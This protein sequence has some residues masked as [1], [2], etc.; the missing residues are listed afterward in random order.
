M[1]TQHSNSNDTQTSHFDTTED[2]NLPSKKE[3][4]FSLES[5][6]HLIDTPQNENTMIQNSTDLI[7]PSTL[8]TTIEILELEDGKRTDKKT[9][10]KQMLSFFEKSPT[11]DSSIVNRIS[12][13]CVSNQRI[14]DLLHIL[15]CNAD[16]E[17][18]A[19]SLLSTI[20]P[21]TFSDYEDCIFVSAEFFAKNIKKYEILLSIISATA[22][23][24]LRG[25]YPLLSVTLRKLVKNNCLQQATQFFNKLVENKIEIS[26]CSINLLVEN[27]CKANK[28]E[29]AQNIM[30]SLTDYKPSHTFLSDINLDDEDTEFN[31]TKLNIACGISQTTWV[32]FLRNLFKAQKPELANEYYKRIISAKD[33]QNSEL[34]SNAMIDGLAKTPNT[35]IEQILSIFYDMIYFEITPSITTF[36]LIIDTLVKH[37]EVNKAWE[38]YDKIKEYNL[39]PDNYTLSTLF[40][41]IRNMSHKQYLERAFEIVERM[42]SED[43]R[44]EILLL[45]IL[46][47]SC[48]CLKET[49]LI[50]AFFKKITA[51]SSKRFVIKSLNSE[52]TI[53]IFFPEESATNALYSVST[54]KKWK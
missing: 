10:V 28:V 8:I 31:F 6:E 26:N 13:I 53:P 19:L 39:E 18:R 7:I 48:I 49:V 41:G 54:R 32:I 17:L 16:Q 50:Q 36:N 27:L 30:D 12:S 14:L 33:Y 20:N 2:T 51:E 35:K 5:N 22:E 40:R 15:L 21:L 3:E 47:D 4:T 23:N 34:I 37:A 1:Q 29:E 52:T 11:Q 42:T 44:I 38:F 25:I 43:K 46:L 24:G 45:N 9:L